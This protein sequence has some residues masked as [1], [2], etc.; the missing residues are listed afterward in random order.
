MLFGDVKSGEVVEGVVGEARGNFERGSLESEGK[1][2]V[3][4]QGK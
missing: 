2:E 1:R 4:Y 3:G